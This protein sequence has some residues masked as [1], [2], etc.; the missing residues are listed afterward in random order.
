MAIPTIYNDNNP[1]LTTGLSPLQL[2][3][4]QKWALSA[5]LP[6]NVNQDFAKEMRRFAS[7][8]QWTPFTIDPNSGLPTV[9]GISPGITGLSYII[10]GEDVYLRR[11][12]QNCGPDETVR[13]ENEYLG[14]RV[15]IAEGTYALYGRTIFNGRIGSANEPGDAG[16]F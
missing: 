10:I 6:F 12:A 1:Q 2:A 7:S 8:E 9:N 13:Y 15:Q 16:Y 5:E 14:K 4:A 3:L 11:V